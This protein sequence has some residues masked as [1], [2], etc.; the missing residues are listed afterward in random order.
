MLSGLEIHPRS[1]EVENA[2]L[3]RLGHS[4]FSVGKEN[5]ASLLFNAYQTAGLA[6]RRRA[7]RED[8]EQEHHDV[9]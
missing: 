4:P 6:A 2:I 5:M 1:P 9:R 8:V 7:F 3:K